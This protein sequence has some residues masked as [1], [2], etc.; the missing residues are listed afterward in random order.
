MFSEVSARSTEAGHRLRQECEGQRRRECSEAARCPL[1]TEQPSESGAQ[2][3]RTSEFTFPDRDDAP[4]EGLECGSRSSVASDVPTELLQPEPEIALRRV[5]VL[6]VR[7]PMPKA[8]VYNDDGSVPSENHIGT[9]RELSHVQPEAETQ[10][11][12]NRPYLTF[13]YRVPTSNP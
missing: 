3:I 4:A 5:G 13:R 9:A 2:L 1:S 10:S 6:A 8:S 11:V 7:V 12:K